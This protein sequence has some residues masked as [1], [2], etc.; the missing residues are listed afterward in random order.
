MWILADAIVVSACFMA[1]SV[2]V[3]FPVK[4]A[5][6]KRTSKVIMLS[7]ITSK[8]GSEEFQLRVHPTIGLKRAAR[9]LAKALTA[10]I[11]FVFSGFLTHDQTLKESK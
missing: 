3:R 9:S 11:A 5:D 2:R 6:W 10:S 8:I 4:A 1:I 7:M